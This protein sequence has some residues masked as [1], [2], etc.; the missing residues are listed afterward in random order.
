MKSILT[1]TVLLTFFTIIFAQNTPNIQ[2][3]RYN[4]KTKTIEL[5]VQYSGGCDEHK[6]QLKIG[7]CLESYPVQC[8]AKLI[9]LTTNDYC[10]ALI[11]RKVLI[12]LH[13]AGLDNSYYTGA[14]ILIHGARDSK[15]RVILP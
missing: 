9:D 8:D 1:I 6:F 10:K 4:S 2:D 14:S 5:N 7:T 15:T 13:E 3:G 11:Q 12:D